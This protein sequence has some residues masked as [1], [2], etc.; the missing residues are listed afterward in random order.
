MTIIIIIGIVKDILMWNKL[1]YL[2]LL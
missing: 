2:L 1:I